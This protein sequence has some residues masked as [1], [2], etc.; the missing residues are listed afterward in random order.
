MLGDKTPSHPDRLGARFGQHLFQQV[1]IDVAALGLTRGRVLAQSGAQ[2]QRFVRFADEHR[3]TVGLGIEG[4][5][6]QRCAV[7]LIEL[8]RRVYETHRGFTAVDDG[9]TLKFVLHKFSDRP[10]VTATRLS[11]FMP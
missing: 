4:D 5:G 6:T 9:H 11:S 8:A 3:V 7:L 1:V 10:I 2:R